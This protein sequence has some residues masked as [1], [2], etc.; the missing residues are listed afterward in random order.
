MNRL[1]CKRQV[2]VVSALVEGNS[3][4]ATARMTNVSKPT[5]LKL[6]ADVG[7]ACQA[8][9][10]KTLRNLT[11]KAICADTKLVP[12][13]LVASRNLTAAQAFM[14][15]LASRLKH[16]VHL[17]TDGHKTYLEAVEGAFGSEVD[18]KRSPFEL[19][20]GIRENGAQ[21]NGG[22][23]HGTTDMDR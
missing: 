21:G 23:R 15:D 20:S 9:Q 8:Y 10:D 17:T 1:D 22:A 19:D 4:R 7:H 6:L 18:S 14:G 5:I 2:Q 16:R 12:T 3:I 13:W 11:C